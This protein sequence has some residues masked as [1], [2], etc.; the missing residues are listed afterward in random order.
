MTCHWID[1]ATLN[2]KKSVLACRRLIGS[3]KYD[4]IAKVIDEIHTE[5]K[6]EQKVKTTTTDNGSNFVKAFR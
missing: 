2:R 4:A 6:I 1:K 5:F 3:H